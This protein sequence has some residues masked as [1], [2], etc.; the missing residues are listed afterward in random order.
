MFLPDTFYHN[1]LFL[2]KSE[3]WLGM[4]FELVKVSI[5]EIVRNRK[6]KEKTRQ[7]RFHLGVLCSVLIHHI[8]A[9]EH[10][11]QCAE[12][13]P[14]SFQRVSLLW[15]TTLKKEVTIAKKGETELNLGPH[16]SSSMHDI[17]LLL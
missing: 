16:Q 6:E 13:H 17:Y 8:R 9:Y 10:T 2:S 12:T 3:P 14:F 11:D 1:A 5:G 4:P 15:V 7:S